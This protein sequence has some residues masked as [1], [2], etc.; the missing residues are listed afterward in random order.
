[1]R[2]RSFLALIAVLSFSGLCWPQ[3]GTGGTSSANSTS[4]PEGK[5]FDGYH[6]EQSIELGYRFTEQAGSG[7]MFDTLLNQHTGP[8]FLDQTLSMH[9]LNN[10]GVL[11]DDLSVS[12]FGWGGDPENVGRVRVSKNKYYD[13]NFLFRRDQ[14]FFDYDLLA[15]PLNPATSTPNIPVTFSPHQMQIRRRMYDSSLTLLPQSKVSFRLGFS[16]NRSEGPSLSSFHEGTDPLFNQL[17]NVSSNQFNFGVDLKVLPR[18]N[19]S[20]DQFLEYDKN[21][22]DYTLNPFA[23]FLL[24]NGEPVSLGLPI[25]S[26]ASQPCGTVFTKG[27]VNP[28]CNGYFAYTRIQRVRTSTPT[29]ALSF[30]SNPSKKV[31]LVGRVTYSS[32]DLNSPFSEFFDG[33]VT[34]T[35]ERQFTFSGPASVQRVA[36]TG[37]LGVT[38]ALTNSISLNDDFRY[39][40]WHIPGIWN[41]SSTATEGLPVGGR[42][43]LLSPLGPTTTATDFIVN[44]LGQ[45]SFYN[46]FQIAYSPSKHFGMHVGYRFRHRHVFKAEPEDVPDPESGLGELEGDS[47]EVN[48]HTPLFG[49]WIR[50]MDSLRI[51][52]DAESTSADNIITRISPRQQQNYRARANYKPVRWATISGSVNAWVSRNGTL[53]TQYK[54]HYTNVGFLTSLMPND[55]WGFDLSYNYTDALQNALI[56]YNSTIPVVGT[57]VG[58]CP[59]FDS[60]DNPNPNQV[61]STYINH[62]HYFNGSLMFKPVK[63]VTTRI[64]YGLTSTNGDT[65]LLNPLQPL[66]PLNFT[67][68]QPL[69]SL[70]YELV[71][72]WTVNAYWNYDQYNEGS[73]VGPT[74]PRYFHD[75]RTVLSVKYSF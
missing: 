70:S 48:E 29:E 31:N 51:S 15:N 53:D 50:P 74:N 43:T 2:N 21:D 49:F 4:A 25:N 12:S 54:Q 5:D 7:Q 24:P 1:M 38:V 28:S 11:F 57:T 63:R 59:T 30:Q 52:L 33:L 67:Y 75:N 44:F 62:T 72:Y 20:Y 27:F 58:G 73:F 55:R 17:W 42:V 40:N 26:K 19:I 71:K 8:R 46:V 60:T 13:F 65:T 56:C 18:T 64:G 23:Q 61:L 14:N 68:H 10:T 66:G 69:A 9:S 6:V 41:S 35:G 34:R 32:A 45:K 16:R 22:T 47:I 37:D 36:A 3:S 39:D